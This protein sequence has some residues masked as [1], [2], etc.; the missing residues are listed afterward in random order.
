MVVSWIHLQ[1]FKLTCGNEV[2]A[3]PT[4][5]GYGVLRLFLVASKALAGSR[6]K[7]QRHRKAQIGGEGGN[8]SWHATN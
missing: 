8:R 6:R 3:H 1:L 5:A 7:G 2:P 4:V